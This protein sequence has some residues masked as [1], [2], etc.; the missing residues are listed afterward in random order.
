MKTARP[1]CMLDVPRYNSKALDVCAKCA[2]CIV[3]SKRLHDRPWVH[4]ILGKLLVAPG[5]V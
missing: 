1:C 5:L 4:G 2:A 3:T